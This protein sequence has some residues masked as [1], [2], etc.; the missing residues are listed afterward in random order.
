MNARWRHLALAGCMAASVAARAGYDLE[1]TLRVMVPIEMQERYEV[2]GDRSRV[3]GTAS[4]GKFRQFQVKV[5]ERIA[6]I[7]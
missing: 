2:Y 7:K 6:P 4:Y 1:P 3:T 5:D